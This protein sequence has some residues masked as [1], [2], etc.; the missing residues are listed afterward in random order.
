[1]KKAK[2]R[3][4]ALVLSLKVPNTNQNI[5]LCFLGLLRLSEFSFDLYFPYRQLSTV[6]LHGS[7]M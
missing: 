5:F 3:I 2:R 7:T 1:M 4:P 6:G